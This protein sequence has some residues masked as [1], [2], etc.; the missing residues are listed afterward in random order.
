MGWGFITMGIVMGALWAKQAWGDYWTW[1]PKETWAAATWLSYLLYMHLRQGQGQEPDKT[2]RRTLA[3]LIFSFIL[4]Q[5]C[6][7]GVNYLPSAQ[8]FSLH[9]Y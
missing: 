8:G 4:L 6:W 9:T 3:L 1:D 2:L 5:M 7:W